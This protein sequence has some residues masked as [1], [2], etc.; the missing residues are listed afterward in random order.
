MNNLSYY[1]ELQGVMTRFEPL[2]ET[3]LQNAGAGLTLPEI[4]VALEQHGL[5]LRYVVHDPSRSTFATYYADYD[6]GLY[7]D[8]F[9]QRNMIDKLPL[10]TAADRLKGGAVSELASKRWKSYYEKCVPLPMLIYDFQRRYLDIPPD[11]VFQVWYGIYKRIDYSNGMWLPEVLDYVFSHAPASECPLPGPDGLITVYRGMGALSAPPEQAISWTTHPG[12]ALW[13]AIHTGYGTHVAVTHI[14]PDQIVWYADKFYNENEVIVRPGSVIEY[15]YEDMIP[16]TE[17]YI[18]PLLAS[19]ILEFIQYGRQAQKL[20]YQ[21]ES[22]FHYHGL[23]HILRVLLLSL[24]YYYNSGDTLS[25]T[26]KQILIYFSLLHD[27][28]RRNDDKDD[29][30]GEKS[31]ALIHSKGLRI[32]GLRMSKKEYH[33]AELLIRCHCLNDCLGEKV[34]LS[35]S[36][37]SQK[38]KTHTI[39]LYHICKD[40]DGLDRVRFNGLDY[41]QLRTNYGRCLPLVAGALLE[42]PIVQVLKE[43]L[44]SIPP[45]H[46]IGD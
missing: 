6:R 11:E 40:M 39:H 12:N 29:S 2:T 21:E 32:K 9:L 13:F 36:G 18:P 8:L 23:K 42:E 44:G 3:A 31:V 15:H 46:R 27:I 37:L 10:Y 28:G 25:D 41:R 1:K 20:G 19:V 34:I 24:I 22:I 33:I 7:S 16:A 5:D 26:D 38:E 4:K 45:A 14:R 43:D 17:E 30:H 35:A